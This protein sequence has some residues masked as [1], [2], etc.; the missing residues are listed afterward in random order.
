MPS[1]ILKQMHAIPKPKRFPI[2]PDGF[3]IQIYLCLPRTIRF[4]QICNRK[5]FYKIYSCFLIHYPIYDSE[6]FTFIIVAAFDRYGTPFSRN[7]IFKLSCLQINLI[8]SNQIFPHKIRKLFLSAVFFDFILCKRKWISLYFLH[9]QGKRRCLQHIDFPFFFY[10]PHA[11]ALSDTALSGLFPSHCCENDSCAN[12]GIIIPI[13]PGLHIFIPDFCLHTAH[14][15][16]RTQQ[17]KA[18]ILPA[19]DNTL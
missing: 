1:H 15:P 16:L 7:I 10:L 17:E 4:D 3:I 14:I 8:S 2:R 6:Y 18:H 11:G 19:S 9:I 12:I 13:I 5:S